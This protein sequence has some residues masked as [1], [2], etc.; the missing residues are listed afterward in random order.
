MLVQEEALRRLRCPDEVR[1]GIRSFVEGAAAACGEAFTGLVAFGSVV[2]GG[3]VRER[4]DV[5]LALSAERFD[6]DILE[7][8]R[9][10]HR[11][12]ERAVGLSLLL[13]TPEEVSHAADAFPLKL[14]A[15]ARNH[16][17]LAGRDLFEGFEVAKAD[18]LH[19]LEQRARDLFMRTRLQVLAR[20]GRQH[21]L[22]GALSHAAIT[23]R[24]ILEDLILALTDTA[25]PE[26]D[27]ALAA[28][29]EEHFALKKESSL[30][31]WSLHADREA[32]REA[33]RHALV[34]LEQLALAADRAN[35]GVRS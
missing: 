19:A 26:A 8:L 34:F 20:G 22:E 28:M 6:L 16:E 11:E 23:S 21:A 15:I 5:N 30:S 27:D 7:A 13:L 18:A 14:R 31:L 3:Y 4:S 35:A 25:A 9:P 2:T 12:G 33:A 10:A 1:R 24:H 29:A 17:V 32:D